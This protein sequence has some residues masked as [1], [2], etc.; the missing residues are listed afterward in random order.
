MAKWDDRFMEMAGL[1]A[2]WSR[3][4]STQVGCVIVNPE[5]QVVSTG[6]NGFPRGVDDD[7]ARYADRAAKY[8]MI[9]HA[10]ANAVL[11]AGGDVRGGTAYVTHPPCAQCAATLIQAGIAR[12]VTREPDAGMAERFKDSF[13]AARTM[14]RE[15]GVEVTWEC[16]Y[17]PVPAIM[18]G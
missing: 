5:R 6:F 18:E 4:P 11:Q 17:R 3:D 1:V 8:L 7:P 15:A 10:E 9:V 2:T 12:I 16:T 13:G 14:L